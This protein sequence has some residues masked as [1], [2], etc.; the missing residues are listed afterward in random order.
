[1]ITSVARGLDYCGNFLGAGN[2]KD[3]SDAFPGRSISCTAYADVGRHYHFYA[4]EGQ[5]KIYKDDPEYV[6][7]LRAVATQGVKKFYAD[8]AEAF[9]Q[10]MK[11]KV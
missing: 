9:L 7:I 1:M 3:I 11:V 5:R 6:E 4:W 2:E 10:E 8:C